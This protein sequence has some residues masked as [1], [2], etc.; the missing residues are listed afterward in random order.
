MKKR[1]DAL[2]VQVKQNCREIK[3]LFTLRTVGN[4]TPVVA[5]NSFSGDA[6]RMI[7]EL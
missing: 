3:D 4:T 2:E 5:N 1:L 7:E 6:M